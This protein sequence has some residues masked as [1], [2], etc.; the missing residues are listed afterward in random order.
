MGKRRYN[1]ISF[2]LDK[3]PNDIIDLVEIVSRKSNIRYEYVIYDIMYKK[4]RFKN[5]LVGYL[6][7]Y[8]VPSPDTKYIDFI[9][10]PDY[11]NRGIGKMTL[12]HIINST[13]KD[14]IIIRTKNKSF[15]N[16]L[17]KN[18][19]EERNTIFKSVYSYNKKG[20]I[21]NGE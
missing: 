19:F 18:G 15:Q 11:R 8:Q 2:E 7:D 1:K 17:N 16:F 10:F 14:E 12:D 20:K 4:N 6:I 9:V 21:G 3:N 13:A 5:I